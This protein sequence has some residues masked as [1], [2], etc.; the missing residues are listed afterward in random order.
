MTAAHA[1]PSR[2]LVGLLASAC[3][4]V[5]AN[6][7]Y[8]QPLVGAI[9]PDV[10][11]PLEAGSLVVTLTQLGY[12]L[13][14]LL[15]V[16]L[17]DLIENRRLIL[18]TLVGTALALA[19]LAAS[20]SAPQ[21]LAAALAVGLSSV[22]VQM[23]VPMAA[24]LTPEAR[25]GA[26]VGTVMSGLLVGIMLARP[27]AGLVA[28]SL[29]WRSVFAASAVLMVAVGAVLA[30]GLPQRRP[31]AHHRYPALI[32]SLWGLWRTT[33]VLRRRAIYQAALF[34]GFSLFWTAAPLWLAGPRFGLS[35]HGI[36][37]FTL[38]G[39][40]GVLAAPVAGRAADRGRGHRAA[41]VAMS[42]VAASF[43]LC[44][45]VALWAVP[46]AAG[47]AMLVAAGVLLDLGVQA[48]LVV[49]Q[50][51]IYTLGAEVR[52]RL[53]GLYMATFFLGGALGSALASPVFTRWDWLGVSGVGLVLA[54]AA[55]ARFASE[56]R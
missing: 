50:R 53:N 15:L 9:A 2:A 51:A 37:W 23:L 30:R 56:R 3:G 35:A 6:L 22:V 34:A 24:H 8:A 18:L 38:S 46:K 13:G 47:I 54:L 48:H 32:G 55:L 36:A 20:R 52:S 31:A 42:M 49:G 11:L 12:C 19:L 40:A 1:A 21:L 43:V 45:V 27:V 5:V 29:G 28:G 25:R 41:G 17:G 14:L 44:A 4:L 26:V 39:V 16:P 10:G 33:P 7:Y